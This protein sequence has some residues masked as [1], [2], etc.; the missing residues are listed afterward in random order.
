MNFPLSAE[1]PLYVLPQSKKRVLIPKI[2][3]LLVLGVIFY[4]GVLLNIWLLQLRAGDETIIK[5]IALVFVVALIA[6]GT[7]LS[8][9][10]AQRP[11]TFYKNKIVGFKKEL[12]YTAITKVEK[13]QNLLDRIFKTYSL[14]LGVGK[15][16]YLPTSIDVENYLQQ[17][18]YYAK[19]HAELV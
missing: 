12:E 8:Y 16:E 4:L 9:R 17:L 19:Q 6:L 13:K 1:N 11:F 5:I 18:V 7:F 2:F 10:H 15:L 3:L 14:D